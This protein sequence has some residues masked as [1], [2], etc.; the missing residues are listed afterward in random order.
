[1]PSAKIWSN[2]AP[3]LVP[4]VE[5]G[6]IKKP[7]TN[8]IVKKYLH[9]LKTRMIDT[10]ILGCTHYPVLKKTISRKAGKRVKVIDSALAV[11]LRVKNFLENNPGLD[12][13]MKKHGGHKFFTSDITPHFEA[14]AA[15]V[16]KKKIKLER[17]IPG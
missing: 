14:L 9:P 11:A 10:L 6:W 13:R 1:M 2:P 4:L 8:M 3:L 16:M 5:E 12:R 15:S 7:E 17:L